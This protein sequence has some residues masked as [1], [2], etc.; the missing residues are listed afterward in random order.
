MLSRRM[1]TLG[2]AVIAL[3]FGAGK[4]VVI[5]LE[6]QTPVTIPIPQSMPIF[7]AFMLLAMI[8]CIPSWIVARVSKW[9]RRRF[10][11][12]LIGERLKFIVRRNERE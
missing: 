5:G 11:E 9:I 6:G 10:N 4:G 1:L 3:L 2:F 7:Y 12:S 8:W